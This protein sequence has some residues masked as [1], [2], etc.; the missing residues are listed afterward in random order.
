MITTNPGSI[1]FA[2]YLRVTLAFDPKGVTPARA[3]PDHR[4]RNVRVD[5][6]ERE[7]HDDD[8]E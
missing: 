1:K 4:E 3:V 6:R 7:H 2:Q 8:R 5:H